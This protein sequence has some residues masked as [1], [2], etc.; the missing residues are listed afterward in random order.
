MHI[1]QINSLCKRVKTIKNDLSIKIKREFEEQF[2]NP[3]TKVI[4]IRFW[5][6][7]L[8]KRLDTPFSLAF[9]W[10]SFFFLA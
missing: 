3:F 9:R 7:F 4:S 8:V 10:A 6:E 2:S 5:G 1:E